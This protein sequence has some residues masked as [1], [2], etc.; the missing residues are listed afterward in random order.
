[1][2][3]IVIPAFN[4]EAV[5]GRCLGSLLAGSEPGELQVVVVCNG[6]SDN[7]AEVARGFGPTVVVAETPMASKWQALNMGDR[8]A[9]AFPRLYVD[10]DVVLTYPDARLVV[11]ALEHGALAASPALRFDTAGSSWVVRSH[12]RIWAQL[13]VIKHGLMGRGVYGLSAAGRS[14][15][16]EFPNLVADDHFVHHLFSADERV[17]VDQATSVVQGPR[18]LR[19]LLHRKTRSY[20]GLMEARDRS[21]PNKGVAGSSFDWLAVIRT[22]PRRIIDLPA[23]L[24]VSLTAKLW[25]RR[26]VALGRAEEWGRD[27][28]TRGSSA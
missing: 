19:D 5:I 16:P 10:A 17:V 8:M 28:S 27:H 12:L 21:Q 18:R 24:G 9:A 6:C 4:E 20:V 2:F 25:A 23:Y 13:P 22:D 1:M 15:F 11:Q 14:R 7:T 3:S 26:K